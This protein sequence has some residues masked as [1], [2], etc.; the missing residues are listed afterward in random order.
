V[1]SRLGTGKSKNFFT[2]H[3]RLLF[4]LLRSLVVRLIAA[5]EAERNRLQ[6]KGKLSH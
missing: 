6:A 2:V 1:T 5:T 4:F 3:L